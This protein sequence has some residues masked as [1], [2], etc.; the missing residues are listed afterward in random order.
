MKDAVWSGPR[1]LSLKNSRGDGQSAGT[2][3]V[4]DGCDA[5]A[6]VCW[7]MQLG[8]RRY[9]I[10]C[11]QFSVAVGVHQKRS[12]LTVIYREQGTFD[13]GFNFIGVLSSVGPHG[14]GHAPYL[15]TAHVYGNRKTK[16]PD[17]GPWD[18][19]WIGS[20]CGRR[21]VR[22]CGTFKRLFPDSRL[23]GSVGNRRVRVRK[24]G[25]PSTSAALLW[26]HQRACRPMQA[27]RM[28]QR[29][30]AARTA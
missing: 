2:E 4:T 19:F 18:S 20:S 22:C 25:K 1:Y 15:S 12:L 11:A 24:R 13:L 5:A 30:L 29:R 14:K 10:G 7:R 6:T 28:R 21:H 16:Q 8:L 3:S 9:S 27:T 26:R 17:Y 23:D